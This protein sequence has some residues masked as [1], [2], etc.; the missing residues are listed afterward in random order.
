[1]GTVGKVV[2]FFFPNY[3][4]KNENVCTYSI[5]ILHAASRRSCNNK[6]HDTISMKTPV[7]DSC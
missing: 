3:K 1:M 5:L 7:L 2:S 6:C 4:I